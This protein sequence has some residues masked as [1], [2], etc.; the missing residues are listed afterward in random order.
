[1]PELDGAI[2]DPR[3]SPWP[4][5]SALLLEQLEWGRRHLESC[6]LRVFW[7][8]EDSDCP[9]TLFELGRSLQAQWPFVVGIDPKYRLVDNVRLQ[10]EMA[11]PGTVISNSLHDLAHQARLW[12]EALCGEDA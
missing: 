3:R 8:T 9:L 1:M 7:F 12:F 10:I 2:L 11:R 5:E 6:T 4:T